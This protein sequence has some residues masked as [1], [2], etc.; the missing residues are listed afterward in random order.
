MENVQFINRRC[1]IC[2]WIANAIYK[3]QT[4]DLYIANAVYISICKEQIQFINRKCDLQIPNVRHV[5]R[6]F[7]IYK[8]LMPSE[9]CDAICVCGLCL[10]QRYFKPK[11]SFGGNRS[12]M[13]EAYYFQP[14]YLRSTQ[15]YFSKYNALLLSLYAILELVKRIN[16]TQ[17][18]PNSPRNRSH[19]FQEGK[20]IDL[21]VLGASSSSIA[22]EWWLPINL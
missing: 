19:L 17:S 20:K 18:I 16:F 4:C 21:L 9:I 8:S 10:T 6:K 1:A 12:G 11:C 7:A 5:N 15:S 14:G 2:N 22:S 13:L 3:P